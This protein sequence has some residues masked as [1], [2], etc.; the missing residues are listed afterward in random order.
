MRLKRRKLAKVDA[1]TNLWLVADSFFCAEINDLIH[2]YTTEVYWN[3]SEADYLAVCAEYG[4]EPELPYNSW[5]GLHMG[6]IHSQ[7]GSTRSLVFLKEF[8]RYDEVDVG[9]LSHE[10]LHATCTLY[11]D[12]GVRAGCDNDEPL[13]YLHQY[14]LT[15]AMMAV[16][17]T[18]DRVVFT[19]KVVEGVKD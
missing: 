10:L 12:R 8:R 5:S 4:C 19:A 11:R 18:R 3:H 14:L 2:G 7:T 1:V 15:R 17:R 16:Q 6:I 9:I 13:C